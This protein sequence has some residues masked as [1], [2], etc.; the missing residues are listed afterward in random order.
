M[1]KTTENLIKAL[2]EYVAPTPE[3]IIRKLV[4]N[5]QTGKPINVTIGE[6]SLPYIVI[7]KEEEDTY[8]HQDPRVTVVDG[9][10][11]RAVKKVT[12]EQTPMSIRVVASVNGN[13]ATD[14]YNMLIINS[15]GK[16]RWN[17]D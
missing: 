11:H 5:A 8:P 13:I 4:Y 12:N 16:N 3:K 6:T 1:N 7:T 2:Q 17:H 9:K 14:D 10:I 15:T